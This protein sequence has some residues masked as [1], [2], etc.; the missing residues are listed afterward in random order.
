M[1]I[2]RDMAA[3]LENGKSLSEILENMTFSMKHDNTSKT[4]DD[5][6][7]DLSVSKV[8][9][10]FTETNRLFDITYL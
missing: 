9:A 3:A 10:N 8:C 2:V 4:E 1:T 7:H 5:A 6:N